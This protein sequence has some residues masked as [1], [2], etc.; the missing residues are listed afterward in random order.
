M[1][2]RA[3]R[4][5][6]VRSMASS[7]G[8]PV[9]A[10]ER[11]P[12]R[13][14]VSYVGKPAAPDV[15]AVNVEGDGDRSGDLD[16]S[17]AHL[18]VALCEMEVADR[19][20]RAGHVDRH[21]QTAAG[22]ELA[23]V[24]IASGLARGDRSQT[25]SAAERGTADSGI[26]SAT[27]PPASLIRSSRTRSRVIRSIEGATPTTPANISAGTATPASSLDRATPSSISHLTR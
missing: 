11:R 8:I 7:T 21:V 24:E 6:T 19:E 10:N 27:G 17:A 18:A 26:G 4:A 14:G 5:A 13:A 12:G 15:I 1:A 2:L 23:D 16:R 22:D 3:S 9:V 20:Q 25:R